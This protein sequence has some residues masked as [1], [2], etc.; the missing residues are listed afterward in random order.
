MLGFLGYFFGALLSFFARMS[1]PQVNTVPSHVKLS[2]PR[3]P[4]GV[5]H[6]YHMEYSIWLIYTTSW[7][8]PQDGDMEYSI[9]S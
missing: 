6:G 3:L 7:S 5:L 8:T 4:Y 9:W 2:T 1:K